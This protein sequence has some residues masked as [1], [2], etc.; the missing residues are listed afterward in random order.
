MQEKWPN[1]NR[2]FIYVKFFTEMSGPLFYDRSIKIW[3][4]KARRITPG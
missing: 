2:S 3:P 1:S 4:R